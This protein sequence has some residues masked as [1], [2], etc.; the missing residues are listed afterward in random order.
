[1]MISSL[2]L[3][4]T[5]ILFFEIQHSRLNTLSLQKSKIQFSKLKYNLNTFEGLL[6]I[7]KAVKNESNQLGLHWGMQTAN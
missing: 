6:R 1:M 3:I 2:L 5:I 7:Q 4:G